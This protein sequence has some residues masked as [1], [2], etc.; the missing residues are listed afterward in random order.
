MSEQIKSKGK[1]ELFSDLLKSKLQLEY[2]IDSDIYLNGEEYGYNDE[3]VLNGS[4]VKNDK[5]LKAYIREKLGDVR[6]I[7]Y[8]YSQVLGVFNFNNTFSS[9][10]QYKLFHFEAYD[11]FILIRYVYDSYGMYSD[12]SYEVVKPVEKTVINYEKVW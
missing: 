8:S 10:Y 11:T 9:S 1:P 5:N 6:E 12:I 2:F 7:N 3:L 4:V